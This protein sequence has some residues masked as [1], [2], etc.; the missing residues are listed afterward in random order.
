MNI[1]EFEKSGKR[2]FA[3]EDTDVNTD[4]LWAAIEPHLPKEKKGAGYGKWMFLF[5]CI[6]VGIVFWPR[7]IKDIQGIG[8]E[9]SFDPPIE[10]NSDLT[11][12][13]SSIIFQEE[14][15]ISDEA[16]EKNLSKK[17][18]SSGLERLENQDQEI[19]PAQLLKDSELNNRISYSEYGYDKDS[20]YVSLDKTS[21]SSY[22]ENSYQ[23]VKESSDLFNLNQGT[24][25]IKKSDYQG[26]R[27]IQN[28]DIH[29]STAYISKS[30]NTSSNADNVINNA[31]KKEIS[32]S[33]QEV[34]N[35]IISEQLTEQLWP[36]TF[37]L[38]S[39]DIRSLS[40]A[41]PNIS[42]PVDAKQPYWIKKENP[43]YFEI[44]GS[45][46]AGHGSLSL[47]NND[48]ADHYNHRNNNEKSLPSYSLQL[49]VGFNIKSN[50]SIQSGIIYSN[51]YKISSATI[52][53]M[54][55]IT[56]KDVVV[57][58]IV[59]SQGIVEVL[60]ERTALRNTTTTVKRINKFSTFHIPISLTFS[61]GI[62]P[63]IADFSLGARYGLNLKRS[64]YI[65]P[66]ASEEYD[67]STDTEQWYVDNALHFLTLGIGLR[68]PL[69][70][71]TDVL[72]RANYL[73]Q[74]NN[75]TSS[76]YGIS[77]G[78]SGI[79]IQTGFRIKL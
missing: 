21:A 63:M 61:S 53:K 6:G 57:Q 60:G 73:R 14:N 25:Q 65:H 20:Q 69:G 37:Y 74:I 67:I 24:E 33:I 13:E 59:T 43:V 34:Q 39:V 78:L 54:E 55:S 76:E 75:I 19:A 42:S 68:Y 41:I 10:K 28:Q 46:L 26:N 66:S 44:G 35:K 36:E 49:G 48:W 27:I 64:G 77:E 11:V 71:S 4:E 79:G 12:I 9:F 16:L 31:D 47:V 3:K 22:V 40:L 17:Q 8:S 70:S 45:L 30:N 58:E 38:E 7:G 29:S 51:Y 5:I 50:L 52:S 2:L 62:G 15:N 32:Y 18:T 1:N 23:I 56:L 72:L